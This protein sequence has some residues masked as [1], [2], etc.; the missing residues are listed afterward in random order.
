[1]RLPGGVGHLHLDPV[2]YRFGACD[3]AFVRRRVPDRILDQVEEHP[4]ELLRVRLSR[5]QLLRHLRDHGDALDLGLDAPLPRPSH[6]RAR[7]AAALQRPADVAGLEPRELEQV[8]GQRV[9]VGAHSATRVR[10]LARS[11][12]RATTSAIIRLVVVVVDDDDEHRAPA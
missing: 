3:D 4:L 5:A 1:V 9:D 7:Q 12:Y 11:N 8:V 2:R 10:Y 6:Q